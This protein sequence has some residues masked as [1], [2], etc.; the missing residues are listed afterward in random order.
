[1]LFWWFVPITTNLIAGYDA[2]VRPAYLA[3]EALPHSL[4]PEAAV[5]LIG[6][7]T[8]EG[9]FDVYAQQ[10]GWQGQVI[11]L[12]PANVSAPTQLAAAL[13]AGHARLLIIFGSAVS[14]AGPLALAR[15]GFLLPAG[16]GPGYVIW[17]VQAFSGTRP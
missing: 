6:N 2:L 4:P 8:D 5:A 13:Q 14:S 7:A 17:A 1:L 11:P 15:S 3:A 9:A 16:K 10:A 12:V